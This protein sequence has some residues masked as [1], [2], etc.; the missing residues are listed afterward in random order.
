MGND[1]ELFAG[2]RKLQDF[3]PMNQFSERAGQMKPQ[4]KEVAW[5]RC[6]GPR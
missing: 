1:N 2:A 5:E 6:A 3:L 4:A